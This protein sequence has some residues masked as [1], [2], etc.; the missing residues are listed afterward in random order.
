MGRNK[1]RKIYVSFVKK[2]F[3]Y[4]YVNGDTENLKLIFY[5]VHEASV[6]TDIFIRNISLTNELE[7]LEL[8]KRNF[9]KLLI[10]VPLNDPQVIYYNIRIII[11]NFIKFLYSTFNDLENDVI[12]RTRYRLIKED[13]LSRD[14]D[15]ES[16]N[17]FLS[18]YANYSNYIHDKSECYINEMYYV[19]SIIT[20]KTYDF[21]FFVEALTKML[22]SY[23]KLI[24]SKF[25]I[26][27]NS[28]STSDRL[29]LQSNLTSKRYKK[30]IGLLG[31]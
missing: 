26:N 19:E 27:E 25:N 30:F 5:R 4:S 23:Y 15:H 3:P 17:V 12:K 28:L 2:Y 31:K 8:F 13:L 29:R 7:F 18:Y 16:L 22:N 24:C 20:S 11:E 21:N 10:T 14:V 1:E 6:I 9:E